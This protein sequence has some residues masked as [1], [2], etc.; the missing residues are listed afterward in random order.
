MTKNKLSF[1][2]NA[3]PNQQLQQKNHPIKILIADDDPA[4][5]D[6]TRFALSDFKY[7]GRPIELLSAFSGIETIETVKRYPDISLILLDVVMDNETDGLDAV[8][9]IREKL[10]NRF[11][12]I[13]LRTGQPGTMPQTEIIRNYDIND[14]VSK[15]ELTSTRLFTIMYSSLR[16]Y[17]DMIRL[18]RA[19]LKVIQVQQSMEKKVNQHKDWYQNVPV[20]IHSINKTGHLVDVNRQWLATMGYRREEVIGELSYDFLTEAS[21]MYAKTKGFPE[22]WRKGIVVD[23]PYQMI[24][25]TGEKIDVLLS[26]TMERDNISGGQNSVAVIKEV[27]QQRL[28][29]QALKTS[30]Q[31]LSLAVQGGNLGFW[32]WDMIKGIV[33]YND[34]WADIIGYTLDEIEQTYETWE[35]RIHPEDR[36]RIEEKLTGHIQGRYPFFEGE[37]RLKTKTGAWRWISGIG[38]ISQMDPEGNPGRI[39]GVMIDIDQRKQA[40]NLLAESEKRF[41]NVALTSGDWIWELNKDGRY[42]YASQSVKNILG[43][44]PEELLDKTP[45]DLMIPGETENVRKKFLSLTSKKAPIIDL[46]NWNLT[47][48][49]RSVCLQTN[50]VP[51]VGADGELNGYFGVDKDITVQKNNQQEIEQTVGELTALNRMGREINSELALGSVLEKAMIPIAEAIQP[52]IALILLPQDD[53]L[54]VRQTYSF[55]TTVLD[56]NDT[57]ILAV[58][59]AI[60]KEVYEKQTALFTSDIAASRWVVSKNIEPPIR[61]FGAIPLVINQKP[62]GVMAIGCL[63]PR[64]FDKR[65][66]FLFSI[67]DLLAAGIN[68]SFLH[69]QIQRYAGEL[70]KRVELRTLELTR[71]NRQLIKEI[72]DRKAMALELEKS[73]DMLNSTGAMARVGGW[74]LNLLKNELIWTR[75][76]F[77]IHQVGP[78]YTPQIE[79]AIK[80]HVPGDR[81]K[82]RNLIHLCQSRGIPWDEEF[83]IVTAKGNHRWVRSKG[84]PVYLDG[85]VSKVIGSFQDISDRKKADKDLMLAKEEAEKAN[86]AKTDFLARMSHEIRTPMNA[87]INLTEFLFDTGLKREQADYL[88]IVKQ[89]GHHLL[90]I[91]NDI[92]DLSKIESGK[93]VL[94]NASFDL[95]AVLETTIASLSPQAKSKGLALEVNI[96]PGLHTCLKGDAG[97]LQQ[98]LLNL[99]GNAIKFTRTGSITVSVSSSEIPCSGNDAEKKEPMYRLHFRVEDTGIGIH[100]KYKNAIF[101]AFGQADVSTSRKYGGTGLGLTISRQIIELMG[102]DIWFV[103][104]PSQGTV[105]HFNVCMHKGQKEDMASHALLGPFAGMREKPARILLA[106]DNSTNV[107]VAK[108]MIHRL[109]HTLAVAGNGLQV[110]E[111]LKSQSFDLVLMDIE[112]PL[113][114]GLLATQKIREGEAGEKNRDIR[115]IALT[116]HALTGY[117]EKCLAAGM[118]HYISKPFQIRELAQIIGQVQPI[119]DV[120]HSTIP[121]TPRMEENVSVLNS[122]SKVDP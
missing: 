113:M 121:E 49:G 94:E 46:E 71:T 105:F 89:S 21:R 59:S 62:I 118:D 48:D 122:L 14:Y 15:T 116:A 84:E 39:T 45:F 65:R 16:T 10:K 92:L 91:I 2:E 82:I 61:G 54:T 47:K 107:S 7:N 100:E 32:D 112:M 28:A 40:E 97:R 101:K 37:H 5:H 73:E 20:M 52:A 36:K 77:E 31:R 1:K 6:V 34:R 119:Q 88:N 110:I 3:S 86:S 81:K 115:I 50:G 35:K 93:M 114:D 41:R 106:E 9:K 95:A 72:E 42:T 11:I 90:S 56:T 103:S 109:G 78:E 58:C 68:N 4:I 23:I 85:R 33:T 104:E 30:E 66:D 74:E 80:F 13:V 96:E 120:S 64:R 117:R 29:E 44:D 27:T 24:T 67:A 76:V 22:F 63:T 102:G 99:T 70:K 57:E 75:T 12:R 98:V 79:T 55:D 43:Y 18:D 69:E 53:Q 83:E 51:L 38:K 19:R 111:M 25:K 60:S 8:K 26:A 17:D 87:I 108:A